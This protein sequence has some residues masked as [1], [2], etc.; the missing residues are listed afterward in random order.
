MRGLPGKHWVGS[1]GVQADVA[2]LRGLQNQAADVITSSR[3]TS[4]A[5]AAAEE[6]VHLVRRFFGFWRARPL[7]PREQS[8]VQALLSP[9]SAG[10][11]WAQQSQ[12]QRH[13][14][15]VMRTTLRLVPGDR[16]AAKTALLHDV[17]KRHARIGALG[18]SLATMAELAHIPLRG[19][20]AVYRSHSDLGAADLESVGEDEFVVE[21]TRLHPG[22][23]P[24]GVLAERW[25]AVA[26]AD[27][28]VA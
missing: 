25:D 9:A 18:R 11:F 2:H 7:S 5:A 17:G 3:P 13:A 21:F 14:F 24:A 28:T 15:D 22:P 1:H 26:R 12:D 8:E 20:W 19:R 23:A 10:L 6:A 16:V 4:S 27:D